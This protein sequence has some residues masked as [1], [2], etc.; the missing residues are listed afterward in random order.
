MILE[1]LIFAAFRIGVLAYYDFNWYVILIGDEGLMRLFQTMNVEE[2][3]CF[4]L[5]VGRHTMI[6]LMYPL[7]NVNKTFKSNG[8]VL[9]H[10][11]N[12]NVQ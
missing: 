1:D 7:I 8:L 5:C 10:C 3:G 12:S 6:W 4:P 9:G 2:C 11:L